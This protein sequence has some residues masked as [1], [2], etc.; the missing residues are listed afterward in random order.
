M[1]GYGHSDVF[2]DINNEDIQLIQ[3]YARTQLIKL[4]EKKAKDSDNAVVENLKMA[5]YGVY[6]DDPEGFEFVPGDI[7][8]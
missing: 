1:N 7:K 2:I 4:L 6:A 8:V 5:F 3:N